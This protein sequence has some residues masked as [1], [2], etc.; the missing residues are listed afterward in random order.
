MRRSGR[1][2]LRRLAKSG[3]VG[4]IGD[5]GDVSAVFFAEK[6]DDDPRPEG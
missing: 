3:A 2:L 4:K 1:G 6:Y 5:A